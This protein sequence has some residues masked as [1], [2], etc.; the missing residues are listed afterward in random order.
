MISSCLRLLSL[1]SSR[2]FFLW[3]LVQ[4]LPTLTSLAVSS[5]VVMPPLSSAICF[6]LCFSR[7]VL[8]GHLAMNVWLIA[9]L[10]F[11]LG[12]H[13]VHLIDDHSDHHLLGDRNYPYDRN[14]RRPDGHSH[15]YD[16]GDHNLRDHS[17]L[18]DRS[19][20]DCPVDHS[21]PFC[22]SRHDCP[23]DR[24]CLSSRNY[25]VDRSYHGDQSHNLDCP[26]LFG[27]CRIHDL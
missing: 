21:C 6:S 18:G 20:R 10:V 11:L 23:Y 8:V 12:H 27:H 25:H 16:R 7:K 26:Y 14:R 13:H 17:Y 4:N 9:T 15:L 2:C 3:S 5:S 24:N 22:H 1:F 19:H